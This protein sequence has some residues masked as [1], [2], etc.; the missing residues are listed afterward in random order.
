M[1][2]PGLEHEHGRRGLGEDDALGLHP[3]APGRA[4]RVDAGVGVPGVDED[5]LVLL[6]PGIEGGPVEADRVVQSLDL[7]GREDGGRV[8][9][10]GVTD[11]HAEMA[12]VT[13]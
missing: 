6:E 1:G 13:P 7:G 5:L 4:Q 11:A 2:R 12:H 3:H 8:R 10:V 9:P